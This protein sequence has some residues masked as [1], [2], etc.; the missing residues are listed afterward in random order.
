MRSLEPKPIAFDFLLPTMWDPWIKPSSPGQSPGRR[1]W[2]CPA[3]S[4]SFGTAVVNTDFFG[5]LEFWL[6]VHFLEKC[7]LSTGILTFWWRPKKFWPKN[8]RVLCLF[9]E[10][11]EGKTFKNCH[12]QI[13]GGMDLFWFLPVFSQNL[14]VFSEKLRCLMWTRSYAIPST[15]KGA[16]RIPKWANRKVKGP[17]QCVSPQNNLTAQEEITHK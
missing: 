10:D 6:N 8:L 3:V 4:L 5:K 15:S 13:P 16:G 17:V 7:L 1:S 12:N 11:M 2:Y 14:S 9:L